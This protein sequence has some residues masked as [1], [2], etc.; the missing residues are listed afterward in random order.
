MATPIPIGAALAAYSF[1]DEADAYAG[2]DRSATCA[3]CL[4]PFDGPGNWCRAC[5]APYARVAKQAALA[6]ATTPEAHG[7][8]KRALT[9]AALAGFVRR[10]NMASFT[11]TR[12]G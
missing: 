8:A 3:V 11:T 1:R 9:E 7:L 4:D 10:V 2:R 12:W 5:A 6:K